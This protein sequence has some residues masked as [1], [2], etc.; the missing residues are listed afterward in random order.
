VPELMKQISPASTKI[1]PN[2]GK[3]AHRVAQRNPKSII[4][5]MT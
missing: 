1:P 4:E 2:D 5:C 3:L